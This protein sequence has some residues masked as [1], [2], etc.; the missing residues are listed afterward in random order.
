[1]TR[2]NFLLLLSLKRANTLSTTSW[3][4]FNPLLLPIVC[5]HA[6]FK[7]RGRKRKKKNC[8]MW[9]IIIINRHVKMKFLSWFGTMLDVK[10][11]EKK[12][13]EFHDDFLVNV[14]WWTMVTNEKFLNDKLKLTSRYATGCRNAGKKLEFCLNKIWSFTLKILEYFEVVE[15]FKI[16]VSIW[17]QDILK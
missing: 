12:L 16:M 8:D 11:D 2:Y 5:S 17:I 9:K 4:N 3:F 10:G 13:N 7:V 14:S 1:M 15:K 6:C